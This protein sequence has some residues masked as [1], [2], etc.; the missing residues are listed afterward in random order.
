MKVKVNQ[1]IIL[2]IAQMKTIIAEMEENVRKAPVM[3]NT[4]RFELLFDTDWN[5]NVIDSKTG[6]QFSS[7]AECNGM[8]I[9]I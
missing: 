1:T 7:Y 2:S 4:V 5:S 8:E 6:Y 9:K 3:S